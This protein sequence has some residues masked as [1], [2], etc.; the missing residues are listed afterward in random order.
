[1]SYQHY[2]ACHLPQ[3][4][5][6]TESK[7]YY[8]CTAKRI[9]SSLS[10]QR[11]TDS[12]IRRVTHWSDDTLCV[13]ASEIKYSTEKFSCVLNY[14][15]AVFPLVWSSIFTMHCTDSHECLNAS[16]IF[17]TFVKFFFWWKQWKITSDSD[18]V[19]FREAFIFHPRSS[20][21]RTTA[22]SNYNRDL[23]QYRHWLAELTAWA[24]ILLQY[25]FR[26]SRWRY[27]QQVL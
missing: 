24:L 10:L 9:V 15:Y 18:S 21:Y 16:E 1:M 19:I 6:Q 22:T 8:A 13:P 26:T 20:Q 2:T 5:M 12:Y 23:L 11:G 7:I 25:P 27:C 3:K 4:S 14:K 17:Q